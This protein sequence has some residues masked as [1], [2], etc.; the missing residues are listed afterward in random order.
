MTHEGTI[1]RLIGMFQ[2]AFQ[3]LQ[4]EVGAKTLENLAVLIHKAMTVQARNYHNLEHVLGLVDPQAPIMTLAALF[5][6]IV[7]YQVDQGFL[8][9]IQTVLAPFIIQQ[10]NDFTLVKGPG[11]EDRIFRLTREAFDLPLGEIISPAQGLNEFLSAV[12]MNKTL[13]RFLPEKTLLQMA[14]CVEATIPFRQHGPHGESYFT[15]IA[16]RLA[17]INQRWGLGMSADELH[18]AICQAVTMANRDVDSFS[19]ADAA[20]FLQN[21]WKLLPEINVP[22]RSRAAYSIRE[23]REAL[24]HMDAFFH[25]VD[26]TSVFHQFDGLP[27]DD[28]FQQMTE[29]ARRNIEVGKMYLRLKLLTQAVLE[30]LAEESGGD[31]PLSLFMGDIPED[32][33]VERL[34][35]HLPRLPNPAWIDTQSPLYHLLAE[36][37][38]DEAGFDLNISPLTLFVYRLLTPA[39]INTAIARAQ[40]MFAGELSPQQFLRS[41]PSEVVAP[42]ALAGARMVFTRAE[43][44][45]KYA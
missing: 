12:V 20:G 44:L 14:L 10:D 27:A 13:G 40:A 43:D 22:L 37:Q 24:Q 15:Q 2:T 41:L 31:A 8:P 39:Q 4:V 28:V 34:E 11:E 38:R 32:G 36:G 7:Y 16:H 21:T 42:I 3:Q 23:Y 30:A 19:D 1:R 29:H 25:N 5:H 18:T 9:E 17:D 6:D 35:D 26:P 45:L 33:T